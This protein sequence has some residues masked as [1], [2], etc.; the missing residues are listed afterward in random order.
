MDTEIGRDLL[1]GHT[2][3][4][5]A[6]DPHDVVAE[7]LGIGPGHLDILSAHPSRASQLRCHLI[8]QQTRAIEL[9]CPAVEHLYVCGDRINL[10][11]PTATVVEALLHGGEH[12]DLQEAQTAIDRLAAV[13]TEPGF[14]MHD[15]WLLRLRAML[16]QAHGDES[17]YRDY[18]ERYRTLATSLGFEGHMK[19]AEAM[20]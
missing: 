7:L 12:A 2:V 1:D 5:I 9:A 13:P 11:A 15:I 16:A 18:R 17:G 3:L 10:G 6:G 19:R 14:V 4:A 8:V 20:P